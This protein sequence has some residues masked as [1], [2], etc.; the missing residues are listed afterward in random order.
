MTTSRACRSAAAA[1]LVALAAAPGLAQESRLPADGISD[2][3]SF[4][5]VPYRLE[6]QLSLRAEDKLVLRRLEDRH[7]A[8]LRA[9]EDRLD[10]ELRVLRAKQQA[11]REALLRTFGGRR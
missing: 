7:I 11:E 2:I 5:E 9:F 10:K 3:G 6:P 4:E 8:E 1:A